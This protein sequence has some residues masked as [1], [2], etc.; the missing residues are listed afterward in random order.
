MTLR[1]LAERLQHLLKESPE[2]ADK[3]IRVSAG[4][5]GHFPV[6]GVEIGDAG[7]IAAVWIVRGDD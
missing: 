2:I 5:E 1:E 3:E 4:W 7:D 6:H